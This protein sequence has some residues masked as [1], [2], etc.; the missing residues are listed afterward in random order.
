M[1]FLHDIY[2]FKF[3]ER[4]LESIIIVKKKKRKFKFFFLMYILSIL[5]RKL[6]GN[7][8]LYISYRIRRKGSLSINSCMTGKT[9]PH[10][11]IQ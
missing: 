5:R 6:N 8:N 4:S 7:L 3:A 1:Q 11:I 2:A 10:I 9:A